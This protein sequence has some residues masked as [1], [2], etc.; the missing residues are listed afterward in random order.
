MMD[1]IL[2]TLWQINYTRHPK[3]SV[4]LIIRY[5]GPSHREHSIAGEITWIDGQLLF[6]TTN[7]CLHL[8]ETRF[9]KGILT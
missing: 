4:S 7:E 1:K 5:V 6:S 3:D 9:E 8:L 2:H